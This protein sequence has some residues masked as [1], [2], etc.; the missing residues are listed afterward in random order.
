MQTYITKL[1][2]TNIFSLETGVEKKTLV[3]KKR[4]AFSFLIPLFFPELQINRA[5]ADI[6]L[7]FSSEPHGYST[8][9]LLN[10]LAIF[11]FHLTHGPMTDV[12]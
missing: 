2:K 1:D 11:T 10:Y 6:Q 9:F 7:Q 3:N 5:G 12:G 8:T 4:N